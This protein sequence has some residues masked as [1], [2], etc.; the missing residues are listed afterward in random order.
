M[1][2]SSRF[3]ELQDYEVKAILGA[4][5]LFGKDTEELCEFFDLTTI[6]LRKILHGEIDLFDDI[7]EQFFDELEEYLMEQEAHL[8]GGHQG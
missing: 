7:Y 5:F 1:Y 6:Q 4:Y 8:K 2:Y 3:L